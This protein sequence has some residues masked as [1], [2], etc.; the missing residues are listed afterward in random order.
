[1]LQREQQELNYNKYEMDIWGNGIQFPAKARDFCLL[2]S[3][4]TGS[5]AH[6]DSYVTAIGD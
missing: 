5:R 6:P 4:Q 2:H 3:I 1:M